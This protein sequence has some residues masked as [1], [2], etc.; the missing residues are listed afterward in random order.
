MARSF[1]T[2]ERLWAPN[3]DGFP[4]VH[5]MA[6]DGFTRGNADHIEWTFTI[7]PDYP[8]DPNLLVFHMKVQWDDGGAQE[9]PFRGG[10]LGRDGNPV[11]SVTNR[12]EIYKIDGVKSNV[13]RGDIILTVHQ[14]FTSD[15]TAR[16]V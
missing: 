1:T 11:S 13:S 7:G 15:F 4:A 9:W 10:I 8:A 2:G 6:L 14:P 12:T 3:P 5:T 16:A